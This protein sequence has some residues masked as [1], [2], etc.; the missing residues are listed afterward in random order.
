MPKK[1]H[2]ARFM[3]AEPGRTAICIYYAGVFTRQGLTLSPAILN[4]AVQATRGYPYL[5]QLVGCYLFEY[6]GGNPT[7]TD[8]HVMLAIAASRHTLVDN[9]VKPALRPLS[10]KDVEF[11]EAMALDGDASAAPAIARRMNVSDAYVRR[12]RGRLMGAGMI[13]ERDRGVLE[14]TIPYLD[15]HLRGEWA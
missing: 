10:K 6:V 4:R 11:L 14:F 5:L 12:Y 7:I 8:D 13:A 15:E 1:A 2:K 3:I 9:V